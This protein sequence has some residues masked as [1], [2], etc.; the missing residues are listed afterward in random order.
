[1]YVI[2]DIFYLKF[3]HYRDAKELLDEAMENKLMPEP[4]GGR[5]LTDFTGDSYRLIFEQSFSSLNEF[6][7]TLSGVM[8]QEEWQKWYKKF[9]GHVRSSHREILKQ[10]I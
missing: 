8:N 7:Q 5:V 3:G 2:R 6:E 10:V 9:R 1:M 4:Q